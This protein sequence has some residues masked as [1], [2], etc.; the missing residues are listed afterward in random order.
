MITEQT[1]IPVNAQ[2]D[3]IWKAEKHCK[4]IISSTTP[5]SRFGALTMFSIHFGDYNSIK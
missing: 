5:P 4:Q 1:A 3:V 2:G